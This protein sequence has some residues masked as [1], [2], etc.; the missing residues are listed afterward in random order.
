MRKATRIPAA[1]YEKMIDRNTLI[2]PLTHVCFKNGFRSDVNAITQ[3]AH[4]P[5]LW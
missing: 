2:V 4:A 1:N 3:I 5:A